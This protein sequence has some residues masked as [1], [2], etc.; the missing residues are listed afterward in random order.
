[1]SLPPQIPQHADE[2]ATACA[3]ADVRLAFALL[4]PS[5]LNGAQTTNT[6]ARLNWRPCRMSSFSLK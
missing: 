5:A 1:M 6:E 4:A 2:T 3:T